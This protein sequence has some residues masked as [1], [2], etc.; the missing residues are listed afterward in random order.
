MTKQQFW[1][2]GKGETVGC[3]IGNPD[4]ELI[5]PGWRR[6]K[7]VLGMALEG[8]SAMLFRG[9]PKPATLAHTL[10]GTWRADT[11]SGDVKGE[12][13]AWF[14]EDGSCLMR[15]QMEIRGVPAPPV[16]QTGRYRVEPL[17][18]TRFKLFTIDENGQALS[19]TIR[20]FIDNDTMINEVGRITFHRVD[21]SAHPIN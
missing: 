14:H 7:P 9:K 21:A 12:I 4:A 6:Q 19:T 8:T 10:V 15:N 16:T 20:T 3:A 17:D 13:L 5:L 11:L 2:N 1:P 18:R